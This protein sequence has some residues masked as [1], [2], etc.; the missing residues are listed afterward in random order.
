[1]W[2]PIDV[3]TPERLQACAE[4]HEK[5]TKLLYAPRDELARPLRCIF[6]GLFG[7]SRSTRMR[8]RQVNLRTHSA[9]DILLALGANRCSVS[10]LPVLLCVFLT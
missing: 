7:S 5:L 10:D 1:M 2:G 8:L 4:A 3:I 6:L 9:H